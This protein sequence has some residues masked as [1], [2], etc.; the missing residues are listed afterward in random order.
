MKTPP[1]KRISVISTALDR[2]YIEQS[3]STLSVRLDGDFFDRFRFVHENGSETELVAHYVFDTDP[4]SGKLKGVI[5]EVIRDG[6]CLSTVSHDLGAYERKY[7]S[8]PEP[9]EDM[10]P[11]LI[12]DLISELSSASGIQPVTG[13]DDILSD[14]FS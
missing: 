12:H 9:H 6:K 1:E 10:L 13:M 8:G 11:Y 4:V 5:T 14:L 2:A 7:C 3:E